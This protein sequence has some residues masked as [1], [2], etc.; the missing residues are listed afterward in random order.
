M[1]LTAGQF[2]P[3]IAYAIAFS[4]FANDILLLL[5]GFSPYRL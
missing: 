3:L 5:V 1:L 2:L 4:V